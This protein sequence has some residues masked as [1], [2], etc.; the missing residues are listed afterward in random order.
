MKKYKCYLVIGFIF[1]LMNDGTIDAN[2][3]ESRLKKSI[4]IAI[5]KKERPAIVNY[6]GY[7]QISGKY[8]GIVQFN[9]KQI[10]VSESDMLGKMLITKIGR[11]YLKY[12][13][14]NKEY[15]V[16]VAQNLD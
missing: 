4:P 9:K 12:R 5:K 2:P 8:H 10:I 6:L 11:T 14:K 13:F 1:L 7:L 15:I 16:K 3:F